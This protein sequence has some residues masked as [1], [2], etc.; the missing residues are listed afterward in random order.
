M[1]ICMRSQRCRG[2]KSFYQ[3][4]ERHISIKLEISPKANHYIHFNPLLNIKKIFVSR[5]E[6]NACRNTLAKFHC[7]GHTFMIKKGL[8]KLKGDKSSAR[9]VSKEMFTQ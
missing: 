6:S 8:C 1:Y 7:S 5:F 9:F 3:G 2:C 4:I